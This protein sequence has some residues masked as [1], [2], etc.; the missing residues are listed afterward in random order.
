[1]PRS[2]RCNDILECPVVLPA[3]KRRSLTRSRNQR[4]EFL[5]GGKILEHAMG[6]AV[7]KFSRLIGVAAVVLLADR[8]TAALNAAVVEQHDSCARTQQCVETRQKRLLPLL[9]HVRK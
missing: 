3:L 1:M 6:R 5:L 2:G 4:L 7:G 8:R 9:W